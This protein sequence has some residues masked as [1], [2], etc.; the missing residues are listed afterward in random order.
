VS[1]SSH[2]VQTSSL[3]FSLSVTKRAKGDSHLSAFNEATY[4]KIDHPLTETTFLNNKKI[5]TIEPPIGIGVN[6]GTK[7]N[8]IY[9]FQAKFDDFQEKRMKR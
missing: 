8:G 7:K 9:L 1:L 5:S 2:Q 6:F 4:L 3:Y